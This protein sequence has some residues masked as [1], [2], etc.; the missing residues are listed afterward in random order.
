MAERIDAHHHL[1][2]YSADQ[3]DWID[4][5]MHVLQRDFLPGDLEAAAGQASMDGT[6]AVQALQSIEETE[7]L[8]SL[9]GESTLI[10]GVVG[11]APLMSDNLGPILDRLRESQKLKGLRHVIQAEPDDD[12]ILRSDFNRG[13]ASLLNT[14]LVYD[15]LIFERHLPPDHS[16]RRSPPATGIRARPHRETSDRQEADGALAFEPAG[17]RQTREC[18]LQSVGDGD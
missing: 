10:R 17:A 9:A 8:L 12:F 4:E 3:Y 5:S 15:I 14:E 16:V 7:W 11:W 18:V 13:L 6:V 2:R 1:W